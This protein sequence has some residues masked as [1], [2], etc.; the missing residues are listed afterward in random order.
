MPAYHQWRV[1][2]RAMTAYCSA[3]N[4][5]EYLLGDVVQVRP[6]GQLPGRAAAQHL[7]RDALGLGQRTARVAGKGWLHADGHRVMDV[8]ADAAF[9]QEGA[10]RVAARRT[11]AEE[12][13]N[14]PSGRQ[15]RDS[16]V[17]GGRDSARRARGGAHSRCRD[18]AA[19][20]AR[21]RGL[22][23]VQARDGRLFL[24]QVLLTPGVHAEQARAIGDFFARR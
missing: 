5:G 4:E 16:A 10:Q 15:Q 22:H 21:H 3:S 6:L 7:A 11:Q 24:A 14:T 12:R 9:G 13:W 17:E 1:P 20:P 23:L 19:C 2:R 18:G 8:G